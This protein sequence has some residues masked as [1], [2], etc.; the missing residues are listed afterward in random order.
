MVLLLI[1]ILLFIGTH[2]IAISPTLHGRLVVTLGATIYKGIYSFVSLIALVV[3]VV[4]FGS[5]RAEGMIQVWSPPIAFRHVNSVFML[6][7]FISLSAAYS[8]LGYIKLRLKHPMLVAVKAWAL[9]HFLANGDLGGMILFGTMLTWAVVD[10]ISYKWR[11]VVTVDRPAPLVL[12][13]IIALAVGFITFIA[14]ILL[15]PILIGVSVMG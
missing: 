10:R 15:H 1:G 5:Y 13:D 11:P 8:P 4:G 12:G 7:A 14:M 6:V 9:G 3:L 2:S